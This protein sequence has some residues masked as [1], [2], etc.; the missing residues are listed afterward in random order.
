MFLQFHSQSV[1]GRVAHRSRGQGPNVSPRFSPD[2]FDFCHGSHVTSPPPH[3]PTSPLPLHRPPYLH[4]PH[5]THCHCCIINAL[6]I[7]IDFARSFFFHS[8]E[9]FHFCWKKFICLFFLL[10][11]QFSFTHPFIHPFFTYNLRGR[12]LYESLSY[13]ASNPHVHTH[14]HTDWSTFLSFVFGI[15]MVAPLFSDLGPALR[16]SMN[17][18][19]PNQQCFSLFFSVCASRCLFN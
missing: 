8:F 12:I 5:K 11:E 16:F 9:K 13:V 10:R 4:T 15:S 6:Y 2:R 18:H 3:Q 14:T 17:V 1:S 19:P 7:S